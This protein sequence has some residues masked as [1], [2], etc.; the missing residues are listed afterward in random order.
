MARQPGVVA[1]LDFAATAFRLI[2]PAIEV[3]VERA[4]GSR[5]RAGRPDRHDPR[6][7]ARHP[8]RGTHGAEFPVPP[9]AAWPRRPAASSM[10]STGQRRRW[11]APARPCPA[12]V[13]H[14]NTRVRVGGGSNHRFGLDDAVLIKDNHVAIAG[15]VRPAVER[16]RAGVGHLVKIE[17][18]VDTLA[19]LRGGADPAGGCGAARQHG[20]G[21][22]APGCRHGRRPRDH[23]GLGPHPPG[24]RA[25][26]RGKR[27]GSA[28]GRLADAQRARCWISGWI[29]ESSVS[30]RQPCPTTC[31]SSP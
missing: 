3:L 27:R 28:V 10:R 20:P 17:L 13:R 31:A 11:C 6:P 26:D 29:I 18:E 15:G 25:G 8:D 14:R 16:A 19:Q 23:R 5:L 22:A 2:D 4:D 30:R 7:G 1:G 9:L 21:H 24:Y 12:C